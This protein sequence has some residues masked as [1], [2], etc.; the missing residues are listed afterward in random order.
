MFSAVA[1][2]RLVFRVTLLLAL[3]SHF[4]AAACAQLVSR[5]T[6]LHAVYSGHCVF[7]LRVYDKLQP[8]RVGIAK[9]ML[10]HSGAEFSKFWQNEQL[11]VD[12]VIHR[13]GDSGFA[14]R[15][16]GRGGRAWSCKGPDHVDGPSE[17]EH[18]LRFTSPKPANHGPRRADGLRGEGLGILA[19]IARL[20]PYRS[21]DGTSVL[22]ACCIALRY[23]T[24]SRLLPVFLLDKVTSW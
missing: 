15:P 22:G 24:F 5:M 1:R 21:T 14:L 7:F 6:V 20:S 4:S 3:V 16:V 11:L 12:D 2:A 10:H 19:S 18:T 17:N 13:V 9:L 8:Q 23:R